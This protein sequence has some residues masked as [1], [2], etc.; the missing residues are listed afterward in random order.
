MKAGNKSDR[1]GKEKISSLLIKLSI[2]AIVGMVIQSLYN[3]IDSMYVGKLST[4]ALSA[5]S[6][7]FP[8]QMILI[9][10]GVG[11]GVGTSSLIS[12][13]LGEGKKKR[14]NNTAEHV[15]F[16]AI[17][18]GIIVGII[19]YFYAENLIHL[20]TSD[21]VLIELGEQYIKIILTGSLAVFMPATFNYILR[22]E[23]NTFLPMVTML[24]GAITNIILDPFL[25]FGIGFFPQLGVA[26]AAYAT[27]FSRL[28]GGIFI[29]IILFSDKNELN[30][31]LKQ[32]KFNFQIIK[33]I[34]QVGL[35]AMANRLLFSTVMVLINKILGSFN[36]SAI[37]VMGIIFRLQSFFLMCVFGLNQGYL[38]LVGYNFGHKKPERMKRTIY[39][40]SV[41]A[42]GF[43]VFGFIIFQSFPELLLRLFNNDPV[44][45]EIGIP[46]LKR[47][48]ISYLFMVLNIIGVATFQAIGKGLPSFII[49]ALRQVVLLL[50]GMYILGQIFGLNATWVAFPLAEGITFIIVTTWLLT[51]LKKSIKKMDKIEYSTI[52]SR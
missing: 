5:L 43:G 47:V 32:F 25:I 1:L 22:G 19:G 4:E 10:I 23:G 2:P 9:A 15:F 6:L 29:T 33:E 44:L 30:L 46:A 48:S 34:Y 12:R 35:P 51:T 26:G 38:P 41:T 49:T 45:L 13:L 50:S 39:L 8:I 3:I 37:A 36:T 21:P 14:A 20:F 31:N 11:T 7:A 18:Y 16:L 28:L 27:V 17:L 42:F 40:G 24:I 52:N